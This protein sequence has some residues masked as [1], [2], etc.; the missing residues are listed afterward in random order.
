MVCYDAMMTAGHSVL[1][2]CS[3][4]SLSRHLGGSHDEIKYNGNESS[5][6]S[7]KSNHRVTIVTVIIEKIVFF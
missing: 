1:A 3:R 2:K 4:V 5:S 7:K 6:N